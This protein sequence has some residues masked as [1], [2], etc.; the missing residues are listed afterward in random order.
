MNLNSPLS[1]RSTTYRDLYVHFYT[2][3]QGLGYPRPR[4]QF[5]DAPEANQTLARGFV[6][7]VLIGNSILARSCD[8]SIT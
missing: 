7:E 6:G 5:V 4:Q 2:Y 1:P 3:Y 8:F